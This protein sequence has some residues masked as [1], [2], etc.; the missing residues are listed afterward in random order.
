MN[1]Y[2]KYAEITRLREGT[3]NRLAGGS[4]LLQNTVRK[5]IWYG[6]CNEGSVIRAGSG[7]PA[8]EDFVSW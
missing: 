4:E 8:P 7:L 5:V 6:I 2:A 1:L 3:G